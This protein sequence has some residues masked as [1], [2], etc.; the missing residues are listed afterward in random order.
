M[1]KPLVGVVISSRADF[2]VMRRGLE[3]LRIMGVPYLFEVLSP[4]R[5][6]ERL[7]A[8]AT[9]AADKGIE[10]FI[11][12]GGGGGF[13][14]HHLAAHT[15]LPI[16]GVPIDA[17]PLRGQDSLYAMVMS[18]P[19][20]PVATV[21][22]NNAENAALLA[23]QILA[24]KHI[25]VRRV[26]AHRR[27]AGSQRIDV[28]QKE[29]GDEYPDL[30]LPERTMPALASLGGDVDTEGG[31]RTPTP[32]DQDAPP[33][34][35]PERGDWIRPGATLVD[36]PSSA[37][38]AGLVQTPVPQEPAAPQRPS[39]GQVNV[40]AL[41]GTLV[42]PEPKPTIVSSTQPAAS[43]NPERR[44]PPRP[45]VTTGVL[46]RAAKGATIAAVPEN[47]AQSPQQAV[48]I[49][50]AP[51]PLPPSMFNTKVFAI[52]RL[53]PDEDIIDHAMM[54][55]LEGGIL[56]LQTDTVLGLV[57]DATN[58]RAVDR[59]ANLQ[60]ADAS[61]SLGVLIPGASML[62][63]LARAVPKELERVLELFWPGGLTI[64]IPARTEALVPGL[65]ERDMIGVRVPRDRVC[66]QLLARVARPLAVRSA[67]RADGTPIV[68]VPQLRETF[69]NRIEC[70]L[71]G[72]EV[73]VDELKA[74]T[75]ISVERLPFEIHREGSVPRQ[76][77]KQVLGAHLKD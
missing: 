20:S 15:N 7:A 32:T 55:V 34:P 59:L 41:Q 52:D 58:S 48:A 30:C 24:I 3:T 51:T 42:P 70:L 60:G 16:I 67:R 47:A 4:Y 61:R 13:A 1:Q 72:G 40:A 12:A 23:A 56:G 8:F 2:S 50:P 29:L 44:E 25:E 69:T 21:G 76:A 33:G 38:L 65:A 22:I 18:P 26:L 36:R 54:V 37:S 63:D 46:P 19:G 17:S 75:V 74:S 14:A 53:F 64:V 35:P 6:P 68:N 45:T 43:L 57:A 39:S 28:L 11:A 10:V 49:E 77:L 71:D 5:T 27:M 73:G 62:H 66:L 31:V 9:H